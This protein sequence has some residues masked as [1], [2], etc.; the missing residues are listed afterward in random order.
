MQTADVFT[1]VAEQ[2]QWSKLTD[3]IVMPSRSSTNVVELTSSSS[4]AP[5]KWLTT[6][7]NA[8][9][10]VPTT[11]SFAK[12]FASSY[13][14]GAQQYNEFVKA[15]RRTSALSTPLLRFIRARVD[16]TGVI[17]VH[18]LRM[19]PQ[20]SDDSSSYQLLFRCADAFERDLLKRRG[21]GAE[22]APGR[23]S[24]GQDLPTVV[25]KADLHNWMEAFSH[26]TVERSKHRFVVIVNHLASDAPGVIDS[27][28]IHTNCDDRPS[29]EAK[30]DGGKD[31]FNHFCAQHT[32]GAICRSLRLGLLRV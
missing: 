20:T 31:A 25:D 22:L 11:E 24:V 14:I 30:I 23:V 13:T 29:F 7:W 4:S 6:S 19:K 27:F 21:G 12:S 32:C 10:L 16:D 18:V 17:C 8:C 26:F 5:L 15:V 3:L 28:R 9:R 2:Q 1:F